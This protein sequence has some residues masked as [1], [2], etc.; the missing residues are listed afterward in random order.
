MVTMP[1]CTMSTPM[2]GTLNSM[3]R[4]VAHTMLAT[5]SSSTSRSGHQAKNSGSFIS[6][7]RRR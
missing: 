5:N 3:R 1:V 4:M 6:N 7:A 2:R